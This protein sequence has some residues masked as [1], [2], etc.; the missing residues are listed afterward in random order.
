M[1][2]VLV[3]FTAMTLGTKSIMLLLIILSL[4]YHL[5][6]E[7]LFLLPESWRQFSLTQEGLTFITKDGSKFQGRIAH[8]TFIS[9]YFVVLRIKLEGD[10]QLKSKVLFP[11]SLGLDAFRRVCVLLKFA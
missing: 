7:V 8:G 3:S 2:A 6:R 1:A 5:A 11:D 10:Y 9:P 4:I